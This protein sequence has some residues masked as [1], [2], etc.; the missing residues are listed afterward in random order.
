MADDP[1]WVGLPAKKPAQGSN[2]E[3]TW[4]PAEGRIIEMWDPYFS[5][6]IQ[7]ILGRGCSDIYRKDTGRGLNPKCWLAYPD[8]GMD[9]QTNCSKTTRQDVAEE[10]LLTCWKSNDAR[11][12]GFI[13]TRRW[14]SRSDIYLVPLTR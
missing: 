2:V 10:D 12:V 6:L 3:T 14:K 5:G 7:S 11:W 9:E 8:K 1:D 4:K 13:M